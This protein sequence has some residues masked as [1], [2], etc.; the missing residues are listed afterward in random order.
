[1]L[2]S[3]DN[4]T[5]PSKGNYIGLGTNMCKNI[6]NQLFKRKKT[7]TGKIKNISPKLI[8]QFLNGNGRVAPTQ[9]GYTFDNNERI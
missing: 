6:V 1:M 9:Y 8:R 5:L 7:V 3:H 4:V 2:K